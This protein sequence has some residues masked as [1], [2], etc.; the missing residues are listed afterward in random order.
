MAATP[1]NRPSCIRWVRG[2]WL[3]QKAVRFKQPRG[4]ENSFKRQFRTLSYIKQGM[5]AVREI[6]DPQHG[7]IL[8]RNILSSDASVKPP[9]SKLRFA[10]GDRVGVDGVVLDNPDRLSDHIIGLQ[11]MLRPYERKIIG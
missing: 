9:L 7:H 1:G 8:G 10:F 6:E 11:Q 5:V 3:A 4:S 2:V